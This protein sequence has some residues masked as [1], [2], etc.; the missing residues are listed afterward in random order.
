MVVCVW[1]VC[2]WEWA[3]EILFDSVGAKIWV[4]G[5]VHGVRACVSGWIP[6]ELRSMNA[7]VRESFET[8]SL[9]RKARCG[10]GARGVSP[11][12]TKSSSNISNAK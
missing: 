10:Y 2:V 5:V 3:I 7:S 11:S 8:R 1:V 12:S 6:Q 4:S 9:T